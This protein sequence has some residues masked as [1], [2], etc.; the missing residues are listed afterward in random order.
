MFTERSATAIRTRSTAVAAGTRLRRRL[1]TF[2]FAGFCTLLTGV[3]WA[4]PP[5][6]RSLAAPD[7]RAIEK[8][9]RQQIDAFARDDAD[10]AFAY[11]SPD[12]QRR[13]G[14]SDRFLDVVREHYEPVYRASGVQ[15][16]GLSRVDRQW[17]QTAVVTDDAGRVWRA[18][19]TMRRQ[20]DHRW[21]VGGCRLVETG[22]WST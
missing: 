11:A 12:V 18:S 13:F 19:F 10:R 17:V 8:T 3:A 20:R 6:S 21:T 1:A 16:V 15:F 9:I 5:A 2:A 7:R 4:A 14:T 22:A